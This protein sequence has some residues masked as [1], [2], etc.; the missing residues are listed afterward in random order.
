[1]AENSDEG[2]CGSLSNLLGFCGGQC[3]IVEI[4]FRF[5][6]IVFEFISF[7]PVHAPDNVSLVF[8]RLFP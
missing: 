3:F 2:F 4:P 1:M 8:A 7:V 5:A 6:D